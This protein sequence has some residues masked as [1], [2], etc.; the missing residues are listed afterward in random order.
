MFEEKVTEK[1]TEIQLADLA[2]SGIS[3]ETAKACLLRSFTDAEEIQDILNWTKPG[4]SVALGFP[5]YSNGDTTREPTWR[6]KP[7]APRTCASGK[8]V[9]YEQP[10][11]VRTSIYI[12]PIIDRKELFD[13]NEALYITEGEKKA[14]KLCAE[15]FTCVSAPGVSNFHDSEDSDDGWVLKPELAT[16]SLGGRIVYIVF[17]AGKVDNVQ[18]LKA[19]V[20]LANM[21]HEHGAKVRLVHI[22]KLETGKDTGVDEFIVSRS[23]GDFA[24]LVKQAWQY[25]LA[26]YLSTLNKASLTGEIMGR[27]LKYLAVTKDQASL[28]SCISVLVTLGKKDKEIRKDITACRRSLDDT[29]CK[30]GFFSPEFILKHLNT[31]RTFEGSIN[32]VL[33][34]KYI[35]GVIIEDLQRRGRLIF[36]G[37][38]CWF[39]SQEERL[40]TSI[41]ISP[42]FMLTLWKWYGVND[43]TDE[44]RYVFGEIENWTKLN[45]VR[46]SIRSFSHFFRENSTLYLYNKPQEVFKITAKGY[47]IIANGDDSVYFQH[48]KEYEPFTLLA[49]YRRDALKD[50]VKLFNFSS[51][52]IEAEHVLFLLKHLAIFS[53]FSKERRP[54]WHIKGPHGSAKSTFSRIYVKIIIGC[55]ADVSGDFTKKDN[56]IAKIAGS[57]V[58]CWDNIEEMNTELKNILCT[59]STGGKIEVRKLYTNQGM[60]SITPQCQFILNSRHD[61]FL[62]DRPDLADRTLPVSLGAVGKRRE[63]TE[64]YDKVA[65][66]RDHFWTEFIA[67]CPAMI[68]NYISCSEDEF[69]CKARM[70][71]FWMFVYKITRSPDLGDLIDKVLNDQ[72]E[73]SLVNSPWFHALQEVVQERGKLEKVSANEVLSLVI[74]TAKESLGADLSKM[75]AV[76]FGKILND[77]KNNLRRYFDFTI[78]R[79]TRKTEYTLIPLP[80][81]SLLPS[82]SCR[83]AGIESESLQ[84]SLLLKT[85]E[86]QGAQ[87]SLQV[88]SDIFKKFTPE[89][90][91]RNREEERRKVD[92]ITESLH[93]HHPHLVH[94]RFDAREH[95]CRDQSAVPATLLLRPAQAV[96]FLNKLAELPLKSRNIIIDIQD[97]FL[98]AYNS[99]AGK[100][101]MD[102]KDP[103]VK[104]AFQSLLYDDYI[105]FVTWNS[106]QLYKQLAALNFELVNEVFD[107]SVT[108]VLLSHSHGTP[109]PS[110]HVFAS[111]EISELDPL[112]A[113]QQLASKQAIRLKEEGMVAAAKRESCYSFIVHEMEQVGVPVDISLLDSSTTDNTRQII[114]S[115]KAGYRDGRIYPTLRQLGTRSGRLNFSGAPVLGI[116]KDASRRAF[117]NDGYKQ[118]FGDWN[119]CHGRLVAEI[120]GCPVLTS[121]MKSDKDMFLEMYKGISQDSFESIPNE[122]GRSYA[123]I[124]FLSFLNGAGERAIINT[125]K[126]FGLDTSEGGAEEILAC[127]NTTFPSVMELH[128]RLGVEQTITTLGGRKI[129]VSKC[130]V[131][132][133]A[134]I[135]LQGSEADI[136]AETAWEFRRSVQ[137]LKGSRLLLTWFDAIYAEAPT[138]L[139]PMLAENLKLAMETVPQRFM[140]NVPLTAKIHIG[141]SWY[142]KDAEIFNALP[143][144]NFE[145][146]QDNV[147]RLAGRILTGSKLATY[148][149]SPE[150][151]ALEVVG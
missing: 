2:R 83:D 31:C 21:L 110:H 98:T 63:E 121:W 118:V 140:K 72:A 14:I 68:K 142:E 92:F 144:I 71:D 3:E 91:N 57:S 136:M 32:G 38:R 53:I 60:V 114:K 25:P 73:A 34:S 148:P 103:D 49:N 88:S 37:D 104:V 10:V 108:D 27:M 113:V 62:H 122:K 112:V 111:H 82:S 6:L 26:D 42:E 126:Q 30:R 33:K 46:T 133:K 125:G 131:G 119:C 11:G 23:V 130:S 117:R 132:E 35:S 19:E 1:F 80:A 137:C 8:R 54:I 85:P 94:Q 79:T 5:Y 51:T 55:K 123:K 139:T 107:C 59:A 20:R 90:K 58:L 45:G 120:T 96:S 129:D 115:L 138:E 24:Q 135:L 124:L 61:K 106:K 100:G 7:D 97:A 151:L 66:A 147:I 16:L 4:S 18:V 145:E 77:Q 146:D 101:R 17:D 89:E 65:E 56:L 70:A 76:S 67:T 9:K 50:I 143:P 87:A 141:D 75:H 12:P 150:D 134:S 22:P 47:W 93:N 105:H 116:P 99:I 43:S 84:S 86:P 95:G 102:L 128:E 44:S 69:E 15:G 127:L 64:I 81:D 52:V 40:V 13:V 29:A 74:Y 109:R 78:V 28:E 48:D 149:D 39:F 36:D 41:E